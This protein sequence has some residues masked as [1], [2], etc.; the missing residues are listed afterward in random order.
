MKYTDVEDIMSAERMGRYLDA[1]NGDTN[2]A[3]TLYRNNL[4]L[5]QEV[6]TVVSCFEVALR[7]AIDKRMV[8]LFGNDWLRDAIMPGGIFDDPK[9]A[10]SRTQIQK[11]YNKLLHDGTYK[12]SKLLSALNM[13]TWKYMFANV[14][15]RASGK[16]LL[17]V[18]PNKPKS[19]VEFNCN[20]TYIFNELDKVNT[21][22]NRIAHH[23]PICFT[24]S[25]QTVDTSY[26]INEYQKIQTLFAWMG[27]DSHALL[28]GLDHVQAVC[29]KINQVK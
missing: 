7:N 8:A 22:R 27:I 28:Y 24:H 12:H 14:Q 1:C 20:N 13:G 16:C 29:K 18:F 10:E 21:L 2:K 11:A 6:F 25:S 15:Y 17:K 3:M 23:E 19:S 4:H 9:M 26:I 5:S